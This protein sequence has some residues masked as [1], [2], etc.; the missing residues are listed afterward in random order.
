[1][2]KGNPQIGECFFLMGRGSAFSVSSR[3]SWEGTRVSIGGDG[4]GASD[5]G[6]LHLFILR[7]EV[8]EGGVPN[9]AAK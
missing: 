8:R 9:V 3:A 1:M 7:F 4:L 5:G 6:R 2:D